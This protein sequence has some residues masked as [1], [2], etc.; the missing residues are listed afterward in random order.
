MSVSS[1][2]H[3][4][5]RPHIPSKEEAGYEQSNP[6]VQEKQ[7]ADFPLNPVVH[8]GQDPEL[9][10]LNKY[11][12][13]NREELLKVD[14]RSLYRHEHISPEMLIKNLYRYTEQN[15]DQLS[16]ITEF[17]GMI[18]VEEAE[19]PGSY[20]KHQD[21]W[22][23]RMIL[24]DSL[25]TMT[26]L[27]ER[28]GMAG[29]VQMVYMDPPYGIAYK[30]NWQMKLNN[31]TVGEKDEDVSGE[32]EVIKA[33]RDTWIDGIHTYLSYLRDRLLVAKELLTPSGSCFVQIS[34]EN[35]HLVRSVM[36]E[37]FGSENFC[38]LVSLQKTTTSSAE[39]LPVV[40]DYILW[41]AKN[42]E[43]AK[44][45]QVFTDK[46]SAIGIREYQ[47]I[48]SPDGKIRR[49]LTPD[50]MERSNPVPEGWNLYRQSDL[51]S[52]GWYEQRGFAYTF[53]GE[54]YRPG[55]ERHWS[56]SKEGLDR[57]ATLGRLVKRGS[58]LAFVRYLADQPVF[59]V[60]NNWSD[61]AFSSRAEDKLY[62]VQTSQKAISRCV[63]MTTD[64]GDLV[65][66]PTCV[67][68]GT[69]VITPL[70]LPASGETFSPSPSTG[71]VGVGLTPIEHITP[72][73][74]VFAHDGKPHRVLRVL[75]RKY[76]GTMIG[77]RHARSP[78]TLWLTADHLILANRRVRQLSEDGRWGSIPGKNFRRAREMRKE[79]T[80][81]E[82]I[83]WSRLRSNQLGVKFRR[84]HPVGMYIPD[85]YTRDAGVAVE[86]DGSQ[87]FEN[88][89]A[90]EY[91]RQRDAY[92]HS[93][94][95][96]VLRF[97]AGE[98]SK[99]LTGVLDKISEAT[100]EQVLPEDSAKQWRYARDLKIGDTL[101]YGIDLEPC[102]IVELLHE[103]T[104]EEVYD[105]EV[106]EAHSFLTEV[107][108]VHNCGSGTTAYVAE[109]WGRRWI[110]TDTSRIALNIAKQRLMAAVLPYYKLY[111]EKSG[112]IRQGFIYKKVPHITL[113]SLANDEPAKE[114]TLYDRPEQD[115]K[116]LRVAGPF[117]VET[118]QSLNPL[119]PEEVQQSHDL[120][121]NFEQKVFDHLKSAGVKTGVKQEQAVFTRIE[122]L[123]SPYLH[124]E[125]FYQATKGERKAYIHIGPKFGTVSKAAV[126]EAIKECRDKGDADWLLILGFSFESDIT[127]KT[128]E[129]AKF[130]AFEV[131]KIRMHDDLMQEGLLKKDKKAA[132]F[133]T[134]AEPD[135]G[136]I[137]PPPS[138][139]RAGVG[140]KTVQVE[141][142]GLDIYDPIKD[143][144]KPRDIHDIAYWMVDDDYDGSNFIVKQA[145][146]CGSDS[147][148]EFEGWKKGLSRL[149]VTS[150]RRRAE[151]TL[152][153]EIDEDAFE[154]LYG[155]ISHPIEVKKKGQ[156][157]A[158]RVISQFG[159]EAMKVVAV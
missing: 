135:I 134:I 132:S 31:R 115:N 24:G 72:G 38:S 32:P 47:W 158:V 124:A 71:R 26:S 153:I 101:F 76:A 122:P 120:D 7:Q 34:D 36:D 89:D 144:V 84:Q 88:A 39:L 14:I 11:G 40:N 78:Q 145:F 18:K 111:D 103:E 6:K 9:Y 63:L 109:Q 12:N 106:E 149:A 110:T 143:E 146:F 108:A 92:L 140:S 50:E 60:S 35:V 30:S 19:K 15:P 138:K 130:G 100:R 28:E 37:V 131:S 64:P 91:D 127:N 53:D 62:T 1:F 151:R 112:D 5:K 121:G 137:H 118:L 86:V 148:D 85:F 141:I 136:I 10:W 29:K 80:P 90:I 4:D 119:S 123:T 61:V 58:S 41:Y 97:T 129:T 46:E 81:P 73:D 98:V 139:G 23:N 125:G 33:Y 51:T 20:Y 42:K 70:N 3:K 48:E 156:K 54:V 66:D 155:H 152:K 55:K 27:L 105:L 82:R 68:K 99:N 21:D 95:L 94:G 44:Y 45:H 107:C 16:L 59:P 43:T 126:N 154:R 157:I 159:E 49:R 74:L 2:K 150:T 104:T 93:L 116:K 22:K 77:L 79:M 75:Q 147:K 13:D 83:L 113:E 17:N 128:V 67:R 8:R 142:R 87:H 102:N 117:T 69:R 114:E 56:V 65:L 133:V 25:L 57:M 96:R 52:Q